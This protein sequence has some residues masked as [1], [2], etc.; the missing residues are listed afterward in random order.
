L[1]EALACELMRRDANL[2]LSHGQCSEVSAG[3]GPR[4]HVVL[5]SDWDTVYGNDLSDTVKNTFSKGQPIDSK[6]QPINPNWITK[7]SYLR[8]LDGRLPGQKNSPQGTSSQ[9]SNLQQSAGDQSAAPQQT[10]A[11]PETA[12]H[13][14]SAEGQSQFDYLQRLAAHLK[15]RDAAYRRKDGGHIGAIG[16]LGSDVYDKLLILQALRPEIPDALFFTTDLDEL[17]LPQTRPATRA[18]S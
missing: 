6:G 11:T 7:V 1:A 9:N 5:I 2:G 12:S 17:L 4:D 14:E 13:F 8:G 15:E 3:D 16:V 10:V 18:T